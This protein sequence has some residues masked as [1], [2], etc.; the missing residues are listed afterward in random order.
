MGYI[1]ENNTIPKKN[2]GYLRIS[3]ETVTRNENRSKNRQND[4]GSFPRHI[5]ETEK[6]VKLKVNSSV[7]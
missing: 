4:K 1:W 3:N 2:L 7:D 6:L 5:G